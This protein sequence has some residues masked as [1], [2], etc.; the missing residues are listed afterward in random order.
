MYLD[1][2]WVKI[3]GRIEELEKDQVSPEQYLVPGSRALLES[4]KGRGLK[5]YLASGTDEIYMKAEARRF[6]AAGCQFLYARR[7]KPPPG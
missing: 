7:G 5:M 1:L 2:L 3:R 4:L 6:R